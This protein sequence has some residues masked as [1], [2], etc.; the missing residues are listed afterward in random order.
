MASS[1][2]GSA[3]RQSAIWSAMQA[4][5]QRRQLESIYGTGRQEA[6]AALQGGFQPSLDALN[7]YYGT[8]RGDIAGGLQ[9]ATGTLQAGLATGRGDLTGGY[10]AA[11]NAANQYYGQGAGALERAAG[12]YDPYMAAGTRALGTYEGSLG[13]GGDEAQAA[14]RDAF[15][16]GPGYQ[17]AVDEATRNAARSANRTGLTF[18]GNMVD[19]STRLGQN[20]ANQEYGGW[21]NRLQGL[22]GQ[23]LQATSGQ[24]GVLGN[25]AQLYGQQGQFIG[26]LQ[27]A[28]GRDLSTLQAQYDQLIASGQMQA[29]QALAAQAA[30][31]GTNLAT[32]HTGM[33]QSLANTALGYAGQMAG[34][35][36]GMYGTLI[37]A[38]QQGLMAGQQAA[39]NRVA[40]IQSG[41]SMLGG[42]LGGIAGLGT[43]GWR[44]GGRLR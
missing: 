6:E 9:Q 39:A 38:G 36:Q 25:L 42:A 20:L 33:G 41:V 1:F 44:D 8:A 26:G 43:G 22:A 7:Q 13:L 24:A 21:Q 28:Q 12:G 4:E 23:G 27:Q 34:A 30:Q 3:G 29:A 37:P 16:T 14:A 11:I 5:A 19:A 40:A 2:S 35:A 17:F 32:L 15:Q 10:G 18:S 31:Q